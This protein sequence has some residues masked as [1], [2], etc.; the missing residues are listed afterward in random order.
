MVIAVNW[1][2]FLTSDAGTD[3]L[4]VCLPPGGRGASGFQSWRPVSPATVQLAVVQPPGREERYPE[5]AVTDVAGY[6]AAVADRVQSI[7]DGRR[8]VLA[9]ACLGGLLAYET[10][11]LLTTAGV[12][13]E[14]LCA[15]AATPPAW[16]RRVIGPRSAEEGLELLRRWNGTPEE[17]L[18]AP[19]FTQ[20]LL[21]AIMADLALGDGYDGTG[22]PPLPVPVLAVAGADDTEAGPEIM[23]GWSAA[24]SA[25]LVAHTLAGDHFVHNDQA[26]WILHRI[27]ALLTAERP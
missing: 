15:V 16:Y 22:A 25:G 26:A 20:V 10:C 6:T 21:P 1:L 23:A 19:G 11:R 13:V 14:L 7:V 17:V 2:K 27:L 5:P 8:L 24:T 9:G 4:L 18:R 3:T 12:R